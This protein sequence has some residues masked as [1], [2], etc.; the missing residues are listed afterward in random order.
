MFKLKEEKNL[1]KLLEWGIYLLVFL[2]PWQTRLIIKAGELNNSNWEYGTIS[3]YGIDFVLVI[4]VLFGLEY[5]VE[6]VFEKTEFKKALW[7]PSLILFFAWVCF[8]T[9]LGTD[10]LFALYWS[11]R[12]FLVLSLGLV[13]SA[14]K[15]KLKNI[16]LVFL[17]AGIIQS[18]LAAWQ[19]ATQQVIGN[20][21]LGMAAQHAMEPG[22][23]V[24]EIADERWL[25]AYGSFSHPNILA[26]FLVIVIILNVYLASS[27]SSPIKIKEKYINPSLF[28]LFIPVLFVGI[29]LTFCRSAF[30]ALILSLIV[31]GVFV[32]IKDRK[33]LQDFKKTTVI[34]VACLLI[35][36]FIFHSFIRQRTSLESRLE[37]ESISQRQ[38][39]FEVSAELIQQKPFVGHGIS[40]FTRAWYDFD[41]ELDN[42][43]YQ[44]IHNVLILILT[45]LGFVGL[46]LF[47]LTIALKIFQSQGTIDR[48][49]IFKYILLIIILSL[50]F[51]DHYLWSFNSGLIL[52]WLILGLI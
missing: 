47:L 38:I 28:N 46:F 22:A 31:L 20:K 29:F 48:V 36:G 4:L 6:Y 17:S 49:K 16:A 33:K 45:E 44:P 14:I 10:K 52:W 51:F 15:P 21:W 23:S 11:I 42:W 8:A 40:N 43:N 24:I 5:F 13:V 7:I 9:F 1:K 25:R 34:L 27:Y 50:S 19:F 41:A 39:Q 12:F 30:I 18:I 37:I 2:I 26:G 3:L 35:F 32:F